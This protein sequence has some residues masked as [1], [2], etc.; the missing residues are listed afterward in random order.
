MQIRTTF[1][2]VEVTDG[3][4]ATEQDEERQDEPRRDLSRQSGRNAPGVAGREPLARH[5]AATAEPLHPSDAGQESS[6]RIQGPAPASPASSPEPEQEREARCSIVD[7][8]KSTH[9]VAAVFDRVEEL[10]EL[11]LAEWAKVKHELKRIL[12]SDL[13]LNDLEHAVGEARKSQVP[14]PPSGELPA[15]VVGSR[16]LR[17]E[18]D[19]A[20]AALHQADERPVLFERGGELVRVD[21]SQKGLPAIEAVSNAALRGKLARAADFYVLQQNGHRPIAP[22]ME[23]VQDIQSS[24]TRA[25]PPLGRVVEVPVLRPDGS[26]LDVPG[27]DEAT[28]LLYVPKKGFTLPTIRTE[29]TSE[30]VQ[31]A[32]ALLYEAIADFPFETSECRA[33]ALG[34]FLTP[35]VRPM[36]DGA[37]PLAVIDAPQPGTGKSLL[38]NVAAVIA[39]GR[40]AAVTDAPGPDE[41]FDKR[42][43]ALL[44]E[45]VSVVVMDN[46]A[47]KLGS[48]SL[49]RALT[50][51]RWAGRIL[52]RSA[53]ADVPQ[54][55]TWI[56]SGNRTR[57]RWLWSTTAPDRCR[58]AR[59]PWSRCDTPAVGPCRFPSWQRV[60]YALVRYRSMT[61]GLRA[62]WPSTER[63][64]NGRS[65]SRPGPTAEPFPPTGRTDT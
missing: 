18:V 13:N 47:R 2:K 57:E 49:S 23:I 60:W 19:D 8:V 3:Q 21:E 56:V 7:A 11:P 34:L 52:G 16:Q 28:R 58:T 4:P 42:I 62:V 20:L 63:P 10:A 46:L 43:T 40:P 50:A 5:A 51:S 37:V 6:E 26:V 9:D 41:E 33:N 53:I 48:P 24:A 54:R 45:G 59:P 22:P 61:D 39:T 55:A 15:I 31:D 29:P 36:I 32:V 12:G 1:L 35:I 30:D 64:S 25:F 27:Y 65:Q 38:A 14:P 17:E 44:L